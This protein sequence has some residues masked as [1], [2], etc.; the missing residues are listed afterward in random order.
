MPPTQHRYRIR[1][2]LTTKTPLQIAQP[3]AFYVDLNG[4]FV[5]KGQGFPCSC[6]HRMPFPHWPEDAHPEDGVETATPRAP[7]ADLV[8]VPVIPA[9]TLRGALRRQAANLYYD[10]LLQTGQSLSP[11]AYNVM[12]C[13]AASGHPASEPPAFDYLL[14]AREDPYFGVFGGGPYMLPSNMRLDRG[15]PP[16]PRTL[17]FLDVP[18]I[19]AWR[20]SEDALT[21]L[22]AE[23]RCD[24]LLMLVRAERLAAL[25]D[26]GRETINA[27]QDAEMARRAAR[28]RAERHGAAEG[29]DAGA[30]ARPGRGIQA[31]RFIEMVIPGVGFSLRLDIEG[32]PQHLG[33]VLAALH[34][35]ITQSGLG[36]YRRHACGELALP[37][38][39][40]SI[41]GGPFESL[42]Q[43]DA[44][45]LHWLAEE[46]PAVAQAMDAWRSSAERICA[47]RIEGFCGTKEAIWSP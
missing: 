31:F 3:G 19:A 25:L 26:G 4:R 21:T 33:L 13:G 43:Q 38:S 27:Y 41:D 36:G 5:G 30:G 40:L 18:G 34:R 7:E 14:A 15:I 6:V 12:Q 24:D 1:A 39:H 45:E 8:D 42:G 28:R 10:R 22:H 9:N 23:R 2:V 29:E 35:L 11:Q 46:T 17:G 37:R 44:D 20:C 32:G 16:T 47:S